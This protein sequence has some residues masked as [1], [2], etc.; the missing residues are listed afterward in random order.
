METKSESLNSLDKSLSSIIDGAT[1]K[2][3]KLVDW[4]Y[5]QAPDVV[6]QLLAWKAVESALYFILFVAL[7]IVP[8]VYVRPKLVK[9]WNENESFED[10]QIAIFIAGC[11]VSIISLGVGLGNILDETA[12]LKILIAPKVFLLE[13]LASLVK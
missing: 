8:L 4:L 10:G 11:A 7:I 9:M 2:G 12:W 13:Y 6:N 5:E 1:E 3:S